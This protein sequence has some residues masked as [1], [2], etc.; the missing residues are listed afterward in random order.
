MSLSIKIRSLVRPGALLSN[1]GLPNSAIQGAWSQSR[2]FS[3]VRMSPR[4]KFWLVALIGVTGG[5]AAGGTYTFY[6][7]KQA[8][9]PIMNAGTG[10]VGT[11]LLDKPDIAPSRRIVSKT[12][13]YDLQLVLFQ[14]QTC[15]FCCKVRAFLDYHGFSYDVIEVNPVMRQQMR[16]ST[17]KKVPILLAKVDGGYQQ[18]NDSSVIISALT[19]YMHNPSEGL[20]AAL[21]YYPSIE[22]KDDEG[23]VKSEVMNRHFLMFGESMPKG[24]TKESINEERKWR[25]W[26]DEVLVHT[27]SPNVYRT[28]DEA[29]QAFNWFSEVGDW[30][31]HF[32]KWER[33]VVIYVGAM[34]MLMIGKRL[35]K[36]HNLKGDVRLS[37]Y[38]ENNFWLKELRKK[39]TP[40]MGGSEPNLADLAVYGVLN[41]IEGCDAF[42]DLEKNTKIGP[43]YYG[44]KAAVADRRGAVV[45]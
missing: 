44:M 21:K 43:W 23:N 42:K 33:L 9:I 22:F 2:H 27:L 7:M 15:P 14:Y 45:Q 5:A 36:R 12:D 1:F 31:K 4:K 10:T 38:D 28:K 6:Q 37:L 40:F 35:K 30:E 16:W 39:G 8:R 11:I 24:K 3:A 41:S 20:T 32:S 17:Y 29:L 25:K 34:A 26:A 18:M 19:S 13:K